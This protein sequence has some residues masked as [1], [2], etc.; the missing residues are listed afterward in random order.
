MSSSRRRLIALIEQGC[1]PEESIET[2][3]AVVNITPDGR[4]WRTFVDYLLLWCGG[5]ALGCAVL[6]FIAYN[7]QDMGRFAKFALVEGCIVVAVGLYC[8]V[9][10]ES[11]VGSVSLLVATLFLGVLLALFGQTYQTGADTWQLF[12][13]WALLMTP[14]A[15]IG[16]SAP[17]WLVWIGLINTSLILYFRTFWGIFGITFS[18]ENGLFWS[19]F[20]F[21][22]LV[23]I[24]W[25]IGAR[26][27][28]WLSHRWAVRLLALAS[29]VPL[30]CL[31]MFAVFDS[32]QALLFPLVVWVGWLGG[33]YIVYRKR[34]PDLFMLA[35]CCLSVIAITVSLG[36]EHLLRFDESGTFLFLAL[37][38]I[39]MG[40][41]AAW[42]LKKVHQEMVS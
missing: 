25:Q 32:R 21:N 24:V 20:L 3:L 11:I 29:G 8:Y 34:Q 35:G 12:F 6:F 15:I 23:F 17:L 30:T 5:L 37:I 2:A 27:R 31:V 26:S 13:N 14:W 1:I 16:R 39:G 38:I 36:S 22:T 19:L 4:R 7:W 10:V 28:A 9:A 41:G 42:W 18:S 33:M 40:G